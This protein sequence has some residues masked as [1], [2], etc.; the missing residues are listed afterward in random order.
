MKFDVVSLDI[1]RFEGSLLAI[2]VFEGKLDEAPFLEVDEAL[3]KR[4]TK[5]AEL[6]SFEG[7]SEQTL[8]YNPDGKLGTGRVALIG[9]GKRGDFTPPDARMIGVAAARAG[10]SCKAVKI[11]IAMPKVPK[12]RRDAVLEGIACGVMLGSYAFDKYMQEAKPG[13]LAEVVVIG[14][15]LGGARKRTARARLEWGEKVGAA[16]NR[17]DS[18]TQSAQVA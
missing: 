2:P 13:V 17:A 12:G 18:P 1:T 15:D 4:L 9:L 6:E 5:L 16:V 7:K 3:N 8:I 14:K 10:K 11:G